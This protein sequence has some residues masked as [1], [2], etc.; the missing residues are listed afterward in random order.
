MSVKNAFSIDLEDW[1]CVHNLSEVIPFEKWLTCEFRVEKS[2]TGLLN[3]LEV[4]GIRATFFVLGWVAEQRPR[5]IADIAARGHEIACHGYAHRFI[6]SMTESQFTEDLQKA[7]A[8]LR[9][10]A[11]RPIIG[12]R[13]PSFSVKAD[14]PW[15]FTALRQNGIKYD[16]SI[17]PIGFHPDYSN[18]GAKLAPYEVESGFIEFPLSCFRFY[19][20]MIPCCG[21]G[22][23]RFFPYPVIRHGIRWCN[24]QGRNAIFYLHPW[25]IDPG[26]PRI[27][28]PAVKFFRHYLNLG[29]TVDRLHRLFTDFEWTTVSEVLNLL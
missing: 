29:K 11:S 15:F 21:G 4:F 13:A 23:F 1:F 6:S 27:K 22:Y 28:L 16:S 8:V 7:L 5:L 14:N 20:L 2:T 18:R 19:R 12:Y 25:E 24:S 10:L 17:F 26:Q 9:P 3:M